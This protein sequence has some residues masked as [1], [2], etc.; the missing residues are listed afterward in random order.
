MAL[1]DSIL[2]EKFKAVFDQMDSAAESDTPKT[3]QWLAD[4]LAKAID[5]QIKTAGI[6]TG[7][8]IVA[9]AGQATGTPN[10]GPINIQ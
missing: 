8:V 5:D 3:N 9:V 7:S 10:P 6:P 1:N 2:S 4:Q